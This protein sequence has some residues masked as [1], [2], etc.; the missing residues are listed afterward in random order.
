MRKFN[1]SGRSMGEMF[2]APSWGMVGCINSK[3]AISNA[4]EQGCKEC[5]NRCY[6][7]GTC[8][9]LGDAY[10]KDANGNCVANES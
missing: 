9:L 3:A 2:Y 10:D 5:T 8:R 7:N 1:E 6:D 4:D